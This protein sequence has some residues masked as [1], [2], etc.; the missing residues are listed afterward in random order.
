[1][2]NL[3][4]NLDKLDITSILTENEQVD[5]DSVKETSI[6]DNSKSSDQITIETVAK[7]F[8]DSMAI[9]GIDNINSKI[10]RAHV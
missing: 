5:L 4:S 1:M 3:F 8:S 7:E 10:G 9:Q 2:S 6:E